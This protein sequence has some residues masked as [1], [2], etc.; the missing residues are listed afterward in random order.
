MEDLK[1]TIQ[2]PFKKGNLK[3]ETSISQG[4][5]FCC[6]LNEEEV[7]KVSFQNVKRQMLDDDKIDLKA[8]IKE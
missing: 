7:V 6:L 8:L 5:E 4:A 2:Q 1:I 3:A